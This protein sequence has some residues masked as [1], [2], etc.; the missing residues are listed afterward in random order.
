MLIYPEHRKHVFENELLYEADFFTELGKRVFVRIRD[1]Y[2]EKTDNLIDFNES[3]S[4][5]E[6]GRITRMKLSRM[7]LTNNDV[8]V[9]T[10]AIESL[11]SAVRRKSNESVDSFD[12]LNKLLDIKRKKT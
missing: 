5:D 10:E 1:A 7:Q 8:E 6:V 9:L 4:E 3:F 2:L 11:K 12:A